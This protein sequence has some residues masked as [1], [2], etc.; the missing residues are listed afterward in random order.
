M[1][2]K[3]SLKILICDDDPAY[4]KLVRAYLLSSGREFIVTEVGRKGEMQDALD[5][6]GIDLILLDI[7]MPE[8]SGLEWLA[9]IVEKQ[10]APVI[11]LTGFGSEEIAVQSIHEGAMDYIPKDH[12]T[13]DRLLSTVKVALEIWKRKRAEADRERVLKELESKNVEL[14][15]AMEHMA[16]LEEITRMK[17]EFL[18]ITSHELRT[19][20]T[21]M[22]AQLQMIL[23]GYVG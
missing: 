23:E 17:S 13:Q 22:K 9:E 8:K 2:K 10:I 15:K 12:L 14:Q 6:G 5:K 18:S 19:P 4:R 21:P 7:R 1:G 11:M 20:L 16:D 3:Q